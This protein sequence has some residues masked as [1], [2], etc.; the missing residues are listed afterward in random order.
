MTSSKFKIGI[1]GRYTVDKLPEEISTKISGGLTKIDESG[2]VVPNIAKSWETLDGGKTWIFNLDENIIWQDGKKIKSGDIN[3][4][5]N[6]AVIEKPSDSQIKFILDSQFSAFP[7]ILTKPLFKK[8]L[9]GTGEYKVKNISLAGGYIQNI[10]LINNKKDKLA[11]KFY[12]TEDRLILGFKLGQIDVIN[13]LFD[14]SQFE[15]WNKINVDQKI[16]YN[17]FVG[18]FLNTE[19]EKLS[20]K[21]VRQGLNYAINKQNMGERALGPISPF[22]WGYNPQVKPYEQDKDKTEEIRD[23]EIKLSTL[24]NL[25]KT[26]EKIA[27]DWED[28]GVKTE[29][30]VV[31][32]VPESFDAFLATVDIPKDPDQYSLWHSTQT[33]TNIS[34]Y[35]NPRID[36]L[37][38]DGRTELDK[39]IRKKIYLDFQR[40]LVE[41]V[42]AIFLYHPTF[43][44]ISRK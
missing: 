34:K 7:I 13:K 44:T 38:E 20:E 43:Y 32:S 35:K 24:P 1:V 40:F 37:L 33:T 22:S 28:A 8:G 14:I 26:A 3:Y 2:N 42:P 16:G 30:E 10:T 31:T 18:I 19:N 36:K 9:L 29:I 21:T 23:I 4:E 15:T 11:Y 27:K 12:P 25:L 17:N 41:D 5:F 39:E 6:D